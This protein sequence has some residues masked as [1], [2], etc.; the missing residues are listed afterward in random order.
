MST[1]KEAKKFLEGDSIELVSIGGGLV[2][3]TAVT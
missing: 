1:K 3:M 2:G